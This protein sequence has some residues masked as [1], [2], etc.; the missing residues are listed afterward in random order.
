MTH[1]PKIHECSFF[2]ERNV[3]DSLAYG[4]G[5]DKQMPWE[6]RDNEPMS[7]MYDGE[8][9]WEVGTEFDDDAKPF[10]AGRYLTKVGSSDYLE[11]K[12]RI[13]W[14]RKEFPNGSITTELVEHRQGEYALFKATVTSSDGA[15]A[16]GHGSEVPSDFRDY[17]E[18]AETK[19][20]GRALA[21]LGYGT[22][23]CDDFEF[24]A[25]QG[26]V[27]DSPV[28]FGGLQANRTAAVNRPQ[29]NNYNNNAPRPQAS[30]NKPAS[31]RQIKFIEEL[32]AGKGVVIDT[33]GMTSADASKVIENLKAS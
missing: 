3:V 19:A 32:A 29:Q 23:N 28:D 17:V 1:A 8:P 12:W 10:D 16:V 20:I 4:V 15:I 11:V 2:R 21:A 14:F 31:D 27:V 9:T 13:V 6:E 25:S 7:M 30:P 26:R 5:D 33:T 18:K 22:Q 24:G